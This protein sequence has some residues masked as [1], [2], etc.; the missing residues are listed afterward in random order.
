MA[1]L[2]GAQRI[3]APRDT[4]FAIAA[5]GRRLGEYET[6]ATLLG[7]AE[8]IRIT[9]G[10]PLLPGE[11]EGIDRP[12]TRTIAALAAAV[13]ELGEYETAATLLGAAE[14]IRIT[15][16]IPLLPGEREGID[17]PST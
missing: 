9:T 4:T 11:R 2:D 13:A 5:P 3:A 10:I 16:G 8:A 12:S 6:T 1:A 14:A 7:A 17:R 15:T